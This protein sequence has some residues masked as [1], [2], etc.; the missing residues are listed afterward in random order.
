[1]ST[2]NEITPTPAPAPALA[3]APVPGSSKLDKILND[4]EIAAAVL[5]GVAPALGPA[6][7]AVAIGV[8]LA[9][10]LL[11]SLIAGVQAHEA[12][13]GQVLDAS[14]L[15]EIPLIP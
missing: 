1:V 8:G 7:A 4:F 6:G 14:T 3:P 15:H 9:D 12:I 5:A 11:K 10:R 2:P 13:T